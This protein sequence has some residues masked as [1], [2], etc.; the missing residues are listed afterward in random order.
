MRKLIFAVLLLIACQLTIAQ[1][2]FGLKA[3]TTYHSMHTSNNKTLDYS[4]AKFGYIVGASYELVLNK[5]FTLQPEVNYSYQVAREFYYGS[6]LK[7]NY[8]QVPL[9]LH[10]RPANSSTTFYAGPQLSFLGSAN[11]KTDAGKEIGF[12]GQMNQTDFG[13]AFGG[14]WIPANSKSGFTVDLRLYKGLMNVIKAEFDNGLKTRNSTI[15]LTVGY[16]FSRN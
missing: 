1:G 8:T 5:L 9:L 7:L 15:M 16:L 12:S 10:L 14:G 6:N 4:K 13:I 2:R 11:V 3:G